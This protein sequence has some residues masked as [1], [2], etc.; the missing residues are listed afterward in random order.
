MLEFVV[1]FII[2]GYIDT[3]VHEYETSLKEK[4]IVKFIQLNK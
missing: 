4:F 3:T 2:T 1:I